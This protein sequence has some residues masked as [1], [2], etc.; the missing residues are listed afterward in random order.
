VLEHLPYPLSLIDDIGKY[1]RVDG[2]ALVTEAF[3]N[4]DPTVP[5][6]LECNRRLDGKTV[7]LFLSRGMMLNWYS[8]N[9]LFKPTEYVKKNTISFRSLVRVLSDRGVLKMFVSGRLRNLRVNAR[10]L[11]HGAH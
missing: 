11:L 10:R 1:L 6:H 3:R 2:I 5:T 8:R 9:T 4:V 7:F